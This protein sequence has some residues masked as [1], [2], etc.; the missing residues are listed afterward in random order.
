MMCRLRSWC[1]RHAIFRTPPDRCRTPDRQGVPGCRQSLDDKFVARRADNTIFQE[2]TDIEDVSNFSGAL[3]RKFGR[4]RSNLQI[5]GANDDPA[6]AVRDTRGIAVELTRQSFIRAERDAAMLT[7]NQSVKE[8]G[9]A[10][11]ISNETVR[12]PLQDVERGPNLSQQPPI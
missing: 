11:T 7:F 12:G 1:D 6:G 3:I 4:R 10:Q 9:L 5:L 2:V 8:I